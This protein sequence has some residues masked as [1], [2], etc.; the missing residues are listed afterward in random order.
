MK[1]NNTSEHNINEPNCKE[2]IGLASFFL[3]M[4]FI[5]NNISYLC[6]DYKKI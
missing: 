6:L 5:I 4:F 2:N 1:P 3:K